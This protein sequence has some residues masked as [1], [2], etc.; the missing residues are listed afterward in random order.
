MQKRCEI[1]GNIV[2]TWCRERVSN[3]TWLMLLVTFVRYISLLFK[4]KHEIKCRNSETGLIKAN[5]SL[6]QYLFLNTLI[7]LML[8]LD[9]LDRLKN[10]CVFFL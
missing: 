5:F 8:T 10:N 9:I 3:L 7:N 1:F 6:V 4:L 2:K